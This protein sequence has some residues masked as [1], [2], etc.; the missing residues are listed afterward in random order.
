LNLNDIP[1][2]LPGAQPSANQAQRER[3]QGRCR[4]LHQEEESDRQAQ[5]AEC[6]A[7][8][9]AGRAAHYSELEA[10]FPN[11]DAALIR[12]IRSDAPSAQGAI[13][14]LLMLSAAA[15]CDGEGGSEDGPVQVPDLPPIVVGV[16]D[17]EKFPSLMDTDGWQVANT[18]QF[19]QAGAKPED[20]ELGSVWRDRAK[21]AADIQAPQKAS[22]SAPTAWGA[23]AAARRKEREAQK[24][25]EE[26]EQ[27]AILP[28]TDYEFRHQVGQ[29]RAKNRAQFG[30]AACGRGAS[31]GRGRGV[32]A[33]VLASAASESESEPSGDDANVA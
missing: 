33:G 12:A 13:E 18:K 25:R 15:A 17:H 26:G 24:Q 21:A 7:A 19:E 5:A 3:F 16:E 29:R 10:M 2:L 28:L 30:R 23:A 22:S 20:E 6:E 14:T 27:D 9:G 31:G 4:K 1:E 8:A 11:L 32:G